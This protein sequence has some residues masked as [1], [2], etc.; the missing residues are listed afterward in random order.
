MKPQ[1]ITTILLLTLTSLLLFCL[2]YYEKIKCT[3]IYWLIPIW[4]LLLIIL[5]R[6]WELNKGKVLLIIHILVLLSGVFSFLSYQLFK[7]LSD[8]TPLSSSNFTSVSNLMFNSENAL[9]LMIYGGFILL[10]FDTFYY[11]KYLKI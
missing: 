2:T 11:S 4:M 5:F 10:V 1:V 8:V 7:K 6:I 9:Y 3:A